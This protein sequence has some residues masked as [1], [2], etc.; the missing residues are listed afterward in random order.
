MII[1]RVF[2]VALAALASGCA[3]TFYAA[4]AAALSSSGGSSERRLDRDSPPAAVDSRTVTVPGLGMELVRV[5]PGTF[6]RG[7]DTGDPDEAPAR[8]VV[9]TRG[10]Y[11]GKYE[12]TQAEFG[13]FAVAVGLAWNPQ[14]SGELLPAESMS[15]AEAV[16]FCQ[17]LT[18]REDAAGRLPEGQVF[19]LPTEAEWE[20]ACRA[21]SVVDYL[22]DYP[23]V[24]DD[25]GWYRLNSGGSTHEV[26][27]KRA[28]TWGLHD[29]LGNVW[30]FTAD[31]WEV[32][33]N[34]TVDPHEPATRSA[35]DRGGGYHNDAINC[36][37]SDRDGGN[38][39]TRRHEFLGFRVVLAHE[40]PEF[41]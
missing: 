30:E 17:W 12:V 25:Y 4:G 19:R 35:A 10:F 2:A 5:A 8:D 20:Y 28:N 31:E 9:I 27:T 36:R 39:R 32:Y 1:A 18:A 6:T 13:Q 14:F 7:S 23:G 21:G 24:L 26:G 3:P 16:L 37:A 11:V 41:E 40:L 34:A 22:D 29:V 15:W 38:L 33:G